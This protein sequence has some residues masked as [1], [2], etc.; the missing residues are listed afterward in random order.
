[1]LEFNT[2]EE[3]STAYPID[4]IANYIHIVY[5]RKIFCKDKNDLTIAR[6][7]L[8]S[9]WYN[10]ATQY[11]HGFEVSS[12]S[13]YD[14]YVFDGE[15]WWVGQDTWDGIVPAN[16]PNNIKRGCCHGYC[17]TKEAAL[18]Y[19]NYMIEVDRFMF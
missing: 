10:N 16:K 12:E 4:G 2:Y 9:G 7:R 18:D 3:I 5:E 13:W 11:Y 19:C 8:P 15:K 1:M 6:S 17:D 14:R